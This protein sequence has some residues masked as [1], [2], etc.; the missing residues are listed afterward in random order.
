MRPRWSWASVRRC[1]RGCTHSTAVWSAAPGST[2]IRHSF[3]AGLPFVSSPETCAPAP[4]GSGCGPEVHDADP[5]LGE[6]TAGEG[7]ADPD[8]AG[9]V[10]VDA[11]DE[12][13]AQTVEGERARD[14]ERLAGREVGVQLGRGRVGEPHGR[15][16]A[17]DGLPDAFAVLDA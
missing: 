2:A 1:R 14:V 10:A 11:F 12:P 17:A 3:A 9:R 16:L 15:R 7:Q 6:Q 4:E 8:H 13:A 5:D